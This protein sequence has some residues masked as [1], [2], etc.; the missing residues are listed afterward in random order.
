M[1]NKVNKVMQ[2]WNM[3]AHKLKGE[4]LNGFSTL[5]VIKCIYGLIQKYKIEHIKTATHTR[6]ACKDYG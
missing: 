4:S 1:K 6:P 3:H 2:S 5:K